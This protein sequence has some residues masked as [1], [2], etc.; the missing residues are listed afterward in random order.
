MPAGRDEIVA[1]GRSW[2]GVPFRHCGRSPLELDCFGHLIV[3]SRAAGFPVHDTP[4][5]PYSTH[6]SPLYDRYLRRVLSAVEPSLA[7]AGDWFL[8]GDPKRDYG[9]HTGLVTGSGTMVHACPVAGRVIEVPCD[10]TL[11]GKVK[12]ALR[13]KGLV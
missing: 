8:L 7:L 4:S 6:V 5:R 10:G 12:T 1:L 13:Y 3:V 9:T 2:L 11:M